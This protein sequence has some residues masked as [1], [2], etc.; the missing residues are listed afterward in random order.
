MKYF[1]GYFL[2]Y[3]STQ[4]QQLQRFYSKCNSKEIWNLY[5]MGK[6]NRSS[7]VMKKLLQ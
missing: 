2:K 7:L 3:N 1:Y 4:I 6:Q 5:E